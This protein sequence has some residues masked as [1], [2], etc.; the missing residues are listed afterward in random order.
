MIGVELTRYRSTISD[1]FH[2]PDRSLFHQRVDLVHLYW[3]SVSQIFIS[4]RCYQYRIFQTHMY[5]LFDIR[6]KGFD[7][8][9]NTRYKLPPLLAY[10]VDRQ[11]DRVSDVISVLCKL[12]F[13][14]VLLINS[15]GSLLKIGDNGTWLYRR[16]NSCASFDNA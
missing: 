8:I 2:D 14:A 11:A 15:R 6:E 16:D 3:H 9:D 1:L 12:L 7:V 13:K 4:V 5:F 10:I